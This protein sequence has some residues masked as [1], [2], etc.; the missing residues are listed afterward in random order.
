MLTWSLPVPERPSLFCDSVVSAD[1]SSLSYGLLGRIV[2]L[3]AGDL[4]AQIVRYALP[5]CGI[6]G[7]RHR[8]RRRATGEGPSP[9]VSVRLERRL[10]RIPFWVCRRNVGLE[11][12]WSAVWLAAPL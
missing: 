6:G 4:S 7:Q 1:V 11:C 10:P 2:C 5:V 3:G 12:E 8:G 9:R